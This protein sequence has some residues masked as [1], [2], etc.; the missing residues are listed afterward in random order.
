LGELAWMTVEEIARHL[1]VSRSWVR[2]QM[3]SGQMPY[4]K[5]GDRGGVLRFQVAEVD[6]WAQ[7]TPTRPGF[8]TDSAEPEAGSE[9]C[10][11]EDDRP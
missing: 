1:R 8:P 6:A 5:L 7:G 2:Q 3:S 10:L 9:H 11:G 4:H